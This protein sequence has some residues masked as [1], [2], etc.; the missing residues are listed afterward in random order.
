MKNPNQHIFQHCPGCGEKNLVPSG[1]KS[2]T[3]KSCDFII[4][5]NVA[6][7]GIALIFDNNKHLLVTRRKH[8]PFKGMLDLPGGFAEP[9]ES[10]EAC[11]IREI[12]EE[13]HLN[14]SDLQYYCTAPSQYLFKNIVYPILDM[15]FFCRVADF[16]K[17]R[18]DDDVSEFLFIP[19]P[20]LNASLFGLDS[21]KMVIKTLQQTGI[22]G[23]L[24]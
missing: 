6:A 19:I 11:L 22:H 20:Q 10:M 21:P 15:V 23:W 2:F 8:D 4:F 17:I 3:C 14:V 1:N 18:A 13:L 5:I 16:S 7:A 9:G 12:K 24:P